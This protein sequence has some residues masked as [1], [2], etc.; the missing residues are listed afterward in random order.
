VLSCDFCPR[1]RHEE[2]DLF[3]GSRQRLI[4]LKKLQ[5]R[6]RDEA[7]TIKGVFM[8][9]KKFA[10]VAVAAGAAF[11]AVP[12]NAA[13]SITCDDI[14]N[15]SSCTFGNNDLVTGQNIDTYQ[16]SINFPKTL[17]GSL[18]TQFVTIDQNVN[19]PLRGSSIQGG[20]LAG[21]SLF[22]VTSGANPDVGSI[23]PLLLGAGTYTVQIRSFSGPNGTYTGALSLGAV[24]EP[25]TWAF[26]IL[27]FGLIG[28][29]I[30]RR[31]SAEQEGNLVYA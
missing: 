13:A 22:T 25:A 31:K 29:A 30:R 27:G 7:F 6:S 23:G 10:I 4:K 28:G 17:T 20:T 15:A 14:S 24:P 12:A 2:L 16:F 3:P 21:I 19:F 18:F 11:A 1:E 5:D 8:S 9:F 26:L